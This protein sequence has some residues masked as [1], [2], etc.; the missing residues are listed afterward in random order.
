MSYARLG[1]DSDASVFRSDLGL[2]CH[3]C[4]LRGGDD[5]PC[6]LWQMV[7]HLRAHRR[8]GHRVPSGRARRPWQRVGAEAR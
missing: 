4:A 2:H 1:K 8:A 5:T 7:R 3:W 6:S